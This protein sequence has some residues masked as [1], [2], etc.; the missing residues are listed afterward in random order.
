M[1]KSTIVALIPD[2]TFKAARPKVIDHHLTLA[3]FGPSEDHTPDDLMRLRQFANMAARGSGPVPAKANGIGIFDAG[4]DGYA[5]VDLIDGMGTFNLRR[6]LENLFG[7]NRTGYTNDTLKID[8]AHGFTPHMTREYV[9]PEDDFYGEISG[10]MI[11]NLAFTF[12][13]IG[14]WSG[15]QRWEVA[16]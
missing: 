16:L 2:A 6:G 11:D 1:P 13:A 15:D 3:Y 8:H 10:D 14:V 4:Q 5:I 12:I 9:I 7:E